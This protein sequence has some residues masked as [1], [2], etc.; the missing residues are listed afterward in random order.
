VSDCCTSGGCAAEPVDKQCPECKEK[1]GSVSSRT[2][3]HHIKQVW[4]WGEHDDKFFF[5]DSPGCSV[6]YFSER[7]Q[8]IRKSDLHTEVGI[9][10]SMD[11][12]L[13]CYCY[14]ITTV[15]YRE[16]PEVKQFVINQ[17]RQNQCSCE[18]S[19]PSGRCCLK[20][21]SRKN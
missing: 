13:L 15:D 17:T 9:K 12:A 11:R 3:S 7:G 8:L 19:N 18:T 10:S 16:N 2:I 21:F 5:C 1:G 14:G 20:D 4:E 6:V